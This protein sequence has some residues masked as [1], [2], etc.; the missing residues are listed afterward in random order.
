MNI[1]GGMANELGHT[2]LCEREA[3]CFIIPQ[4]VCAEMIEPE[5]KT[6]EENAQ[7][8]N[9][10]PK[11][12]FHDGRYI[13]TGS[14]RGE[15]EKADIMGLERSMKLL[16]KTCFLLVF[17]SS[18]SL[19]AGCETLSG[20][21]DAQHSVAREPVDTIVPATSTGAAPQ[22]PA[23]STATSSITATVQPTT[24][25]KGTSTSTPT[26]SAPDPVVL[27]AG[28]I[29]VCDTRQDEATA[30]ILLNTP[31]T[32]LTLGDDAYPSGSPANFA[33]C[34]A[35]SW[36]QVKG[37]TYPSPGNHE[38]GTKGAAGY[39]GY[40]G[41]AAGPVGKGYY[42]F[43]LGNWHL[44]ALNSEIAVNAGSPQEQWLRAD[45][46]A[47]PN[48]CTLAY[49]HQPRFSSGPH[50]SNNKYQALWQELYA[51]G[52]D[53]VLNGHDHD[54]ERF[55][56]Q[57]P[58]GK[59]DAAHGIREFV[60]GTGGASLYPSVLVAGNSEVRNNKTWGVLKLTLHANSYDWKFLST[61]G[62]DSVDAGSNACH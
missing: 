13:S 4:A 24:E 50:G 56:P 60:V 37:R 61:D 19:L 51:A 12:P 43:D 27:A 58:D 53:I 28:D 41:A 29:G 2:A 17:V 15:K 6:R 59:L 48:T 9:G 44:I 35:P 10:K 36:G 7:R 1:R 16:F 57:T 54:Y 33:N 49:W 32:V 39:F 30:K 22:V 55:A 47:H 18:L 26:M 42:S 46:A 23:S 8:E 14:T 34:Y 11:N 25:S 5:R 38:Y 62:K 31:G 40:F 3:D 45:L 20:S 52:A 21:P